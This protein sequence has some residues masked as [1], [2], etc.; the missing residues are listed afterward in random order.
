MDLHVHKG[1]IALGRAKADSGVAAMT[2]RPLEADRTAERAA[3]VEILTGAPGWKETASAR[4]SRFS[5][6]VR[7][8]PFLAHE[9]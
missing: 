2:Q 3:L 9:N 1:G 8:A 6:A 4:G 7:P 5:A